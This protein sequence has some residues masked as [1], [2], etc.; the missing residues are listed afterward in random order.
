MI[1]KPVYV[2]R[3][4]LPTY[5]DYIEMIRPIWDTHKLT[6]MGDYHKRLEREL[7]DFLS[8]PNISLMVNGHI[9]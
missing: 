9:A 1:E 4:S 2:T 3:S 8:V 6:N 7:K 5:E